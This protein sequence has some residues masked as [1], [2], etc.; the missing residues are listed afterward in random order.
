MFR[1][2]C[3]FVCV[4]G[5]SPSISLG[6]VLVPVPLCFNLVFVSDIYIHSASVQPEANK[7]TELQALKL[8]DALC[9]FVFLSVLLGRAAQMHSRISP[10]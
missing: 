6:P 5:G 9:P 2:V 10:W 7:L 1:T 4:C 3:V 8:Q